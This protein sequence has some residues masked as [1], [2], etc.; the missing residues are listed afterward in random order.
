MT[1]TQSAV[2]DFVTDTIR[3]RGYAPSIREIMRGTGHNST[4]VVSLAVNA[5]IRDGHLVRTAGKVRNL[6][7]AAIDL[8]AVP[9]EQLYA[10]IGRRDALARE[11]LSA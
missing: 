8:S 11:R 2:F 7:L 9:I 6:A 5:L 1:P 10:E 4:S 3:D